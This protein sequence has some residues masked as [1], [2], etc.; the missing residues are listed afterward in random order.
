MTK[1]HDRLIPL[2][3][4][5]HHALAQA[6][7]LRE[8]AVGSDDDRLRQAGEFVTFFK[9]DTIGHF[10]EEEEIVFPLAI[11]DPRATSLLGRVV[12]EHLQIHALVAR[13]S[14]EVARG[15]VAQA[16]A[17]QVAIALERH[18]RLEEKEVFPLLEDI[19]SE[20]QMA[21]VL[22]APRERGGR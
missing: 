6:R 19:V 20:D 8:A 18:I 12:I 4:D 1:R 14:E 16:T 7:R 21:S 3:H 13:L 10:R 11:D 17:E 15:D 2:T 22:L 5:H 9:E